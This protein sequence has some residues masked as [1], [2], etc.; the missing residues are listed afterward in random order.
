MI[1]LQHDSTKHYLS[2]SPL[3]YINGSHQNIAFGTKKGIL[4]ETFWTVYPLEN[5]TDIQQGEPIQCGTTLRLNNAALQMFLHSHAIEGPFNHGQEVTVFD[6]KDMGDLWTVE[7][8]DM[9]TAATPFYLKHWETN[10]YL[11]ATNNF[12][13][14]EMLEGYE[15]FADNTTTNN[16]WH[17]QGGIFIGDDEK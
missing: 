12:Y 5:Q 2:S 10:Q 4:A 11:S 15:I 9:W 13:P 3:R 1:K 16:A 7:C 14:A 8:D 6:Q 17:V